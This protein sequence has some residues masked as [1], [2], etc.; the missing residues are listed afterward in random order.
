[1]VVHGEATVPTGL[2]I[3]SDWNPKERLLHLTIEEFSAAAQR[4]LDDRVRATTDSW[5]PATDKVMAT[6]K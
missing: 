4:V 5:D 6:R 2:L 1:M 3:A